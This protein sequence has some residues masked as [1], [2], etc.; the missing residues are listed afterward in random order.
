MGNFAPCRAESL[1]EGL[2]FW[3]TKPQI[4]P[5]SCGWDKLHLC[6]VILQ[7][8]LL[9]LQEALSDAV[10]AVGDPGKCYFPG[11]CS[12]S[13][14]ALLRVGL[15]DQI[16][17]IHCFLLSLSSLSLAWNVLVHLARTFTDT[18]PGQAR[19][20]SYRPL[21]FRSVH[22]PFLLRPVPFSPLCFPTPWS[23]PSNSFF[24]KS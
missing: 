10:L 22:S 23:S 1:F 24:P 7:H 14:Q 11:I 9:G 21:I 5:C 19:F 12:L 3:H 13:H 17:K 8:S 6:L 20:L 18:E 4:P 15:E 2:R 16:Y